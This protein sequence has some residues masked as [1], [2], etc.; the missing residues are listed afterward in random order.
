M[1]RSDRKFNTVNRSRGGGVLF[2]AANTVT[3]T[4]IDIGHI[5]QNAPLI[6]FILCKCLFR[7]FTLFIGVVY[8]PPDLPVDD[9]ENFTNALEIFL[10]GKQFLIVGDFNIPDLYITTASTHS[11]RSCLRSLL[12]TLNVSQHNNIL[13][14]YHSILDLVLCNCNVNISVSHS[15]HPLVHEDAYHPA[16]SISS[17]L[18]LTKTTRFPSNYGRGYNFRKADFASLYDHLL[19]VEWS[20][21]KDYGNVNVAV[22]ALYDTLYAIINLHV[23]KTQISKSNYPPWFTPRIIQNIKLKNVYRR[24]WVKTSNEFFGIEFRKLRALVKLQVSE[25]HLTYL[26]SIERGLKANPSDIWKYVNSKRRSTRI[27][28][29]MNIDQLELTHPEQIVDA[30]A[31]HFRKNFTNT[32]ALTFS[33]DYLITSSFT[34]PVIDEDQLIKIMSSL[35]NK[36]T[37]GDDGVPSF[38]VRDCRCVLARPLALIINLSLRTCTFPELW[39]RARICPV[40]K[41]GDVSDISNYRPISILSNFAKVYEVVISNHIFTN[42]RSFLSTNQH[43]FMPG[44]STITNLAAVTQFICEALDRKQQVDIIYTDFSHAFDSVPHEILLSKLGAL[45]AGPSLITLMDSYL[46]NRRCYVSYNGHKS[47]EFLAISGVPQG[48]CLGPLLFNIFI[49]DLL[50]SLTCPALAYADDLKLFSTIESRADMNLLQENLNIISDWCSVSGLMLNVGKCCFMSYTRSMVCRTPSYNIAGECL[51]NVSSFKDL[52]VLFDAKLS[53]ANHIEMVRKNANKCLG[54]ILRVSRDFNNVEIMK[55]L[56]FAF[57]S[58]KLEYASLIWYPI[59]ACHAAVLDRIHRR[60]LKYLSYRTDGVYPALGTS[61]TDLLNKHQMSS[62]FERRRVQS[63][64]FLRK[65]IRGDVVSE[66][67]LARVPFNVPRQAAR[68]AATFRLPIARTNVLQ[69]APISVM[70]RNA[71]KLYEDVFV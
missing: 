18:Q 27:P 29:Q 56:Y 21:L 32:V 71:D 26:Q 57:V 48:S 51:S 1:V 14:S 31:D 66:E 7:S 13:N 10:L 15:L 30:F 44:R 67:L 33:D 16:L 34:T 22:Q 5:T 20:F 12:E 68:H 50:N 3:F 9:L 42:V 49:N 6:D 47:Q 52:G 40:F 28:G 25:A 54:F 36:L 61:Q 65:L 53:F 23:P 46:K 43:G 4:T 11:K 62:L 64:A 41:K 19:K 39:K 2:A 60:F 55:R 35:P 58:S 37:A 63:A 59:Y 24:K 17:V 45:G 70:C 38:F 8:I 69:R